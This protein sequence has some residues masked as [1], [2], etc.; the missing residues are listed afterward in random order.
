MTRR[1]LPSA[2]F[3]FLYLHL[4]ILA[5]ADESGAAWRH[6]E[7]RRFPAAEAH[8]GVAVD[9][10]H[11]YA[12]TNRAIGKYRKDTGQRA[13]GWEGESTGPVQHLNS[14]IVH[15]GQ[16]LVAHSNF[17]DLPE[18]SSMEIF[19]AATLAPAGRRIFPDPPGSLTWIVPYRN[20]W[21]ACFA[22]Y[23]KTSDPAR[24][25]LVHLD[26]EWSPVASWPFPPAL[27]ERFGDY[28]SSG[29]AV[30]PAGRLFVTGHDAKELYVL[31]VPEG[32]GSPLIW[33]AT[34][35]IAA[36]GQ[37][38]AWDPEQ[39]G[40]LYSIQRKTREVIVSRVERSNP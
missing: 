15:R 4:P 7:L 2:V 29:G 38:F 24:S 8:Q 32:D 10:E 19:D 5:M 6:V 31:S 37:A 12:I 20:G 39:E 22:H 16:L 18:E 23:R 30:G 27:V 36:A 17:P 21:L 33:E 1:P 35:D 11:F 34:V 26:A 14:G 25:R 40:I 28:S 13:G 3:A 9:G